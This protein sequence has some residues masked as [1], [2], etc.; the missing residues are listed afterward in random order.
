MFYSRSPHILVVDHFL[1]DPDMVRHI[2]LQQEYETN[3]TRYKGLRTKK[4]FQWPFLK[5]EFERLLNIKIGSWQDQPANGIFQRTTFK[6]PLV[7]HADSQDYAGA[8][9]L[10]PNA[11]LDGGTS[12]WRDKRS[13]CRRPPHHYLEGRPDADRINGEMF[14]EEN[15][16]SP[17]NWELCDQVANDYNRLVIWDSKLIHSASSYEGF[18]G[19]RLAQL[20]FFCI[21]K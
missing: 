14:T 17:D 3:L 7:Y 2:A 13:G 8:I 21:A 18:E 6:D 16:I 12:F 4:Q 15:V 20:F 11:P 9:Y 19:E 10:T 5:E 1:A